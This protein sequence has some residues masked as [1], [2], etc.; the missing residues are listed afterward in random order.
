M[1][2]R[3]KVKAKLEDLK[4]KLGGALFTV[5]ALDYKDFRVSKTDCDSLRDAAIAL[6]ELS[7]LLAGKE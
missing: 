6:E 4:G 5:V 2:H 3:E 1:S 7:D